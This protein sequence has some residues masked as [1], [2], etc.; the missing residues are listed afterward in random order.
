MNVE[1][2]IYVYLFVCASMIVFN[3]VTA[4][5][6]NHRD[7]KSERVSKKFYSEVELQLERI[8]N[9]M[10][11]DDKHKRFLCKR[12]KRVGNMIAFDKMLESAYIES[13]KVIRHYLSELD[14]VFI[15][16]CY[17]YCGKDR[18]E[19]AYFPYIIKK[20]RL[21]YRALPSL[22]EA[23]LGLLDEPS[24]YCRE[25]AMQALYTTG[26]S[27]CIIK[28]LKKIDRSEFFFHGK[29]L[30]DGLLNFMGSSDELCGKIISNFNDFSVDMKINLLNFFRL[31]TPNYCEFAYSVLINEKQNDEIR[32]C[33]IRYLGKYYY[34]EAYEILCSMAKNENFDK[35]QYAAIAS[36]ALAIYPGAETVELLKNNLYSRNWYIR[37]NSA[38]SLESLGVTY[39]DLSDVIDGDDR[40]A[41]EI[42]KYVLQRNDEERGKITV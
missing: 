5:V 42:L 4:F 15:T 16:L 21:A 27:D 8:K 40:Y 1:I 37:F 25:N 31:S 32:Y 23:L 10:P 39:V 13:P 22:T 14:A 17:D 6:L 35:W 19:A 9:G 2:M 7:K 33:A 3:I 30:S 24:I 28:A 12:L 29:L 26:D 18:I 34:G 38:K 41:S 20:Y 36:T 11:C